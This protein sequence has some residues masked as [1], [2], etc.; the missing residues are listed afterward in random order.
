MSANHFVYKLI[1]PRPTFASDMSDDEQAVMGEHFAYWTTL[2]EGGRIVAYGP[3]LEPAG[4][5][6]LAVVEAE[7][8]DD[9]RAL[10]EE[11]R[12][13]RPACAPSRSA[14][15]CRGRSFA[16]PASGCSRARRHGRP[17]PSRAVLTPDPPHSPTAHSRRGARG[18]P[19][20]TLR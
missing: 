15:C 16:Q 10:A 6:G 18:P 7:S 9:V 19:W 5:W 4:V 2:F 1:P 17:P 8:V 3:V 13:S 14:P 20:P 11:T 12:R